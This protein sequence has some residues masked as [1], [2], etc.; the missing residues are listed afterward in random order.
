MKPFHEKMNYTAH[1]Y[2][3]DKH[4]ASNLF[5]IR[6]N[7]LHTWLPAISPGMSQGVVSGQDPDSQVNGKPG[8]PRKESYWS[9]YRT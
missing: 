4:F 6:N 9:L 3:T 1:V 2:E 8:F 7:Y 5:Q